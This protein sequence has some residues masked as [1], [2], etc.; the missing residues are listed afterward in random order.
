MQRWKA[1]ILLASIL[2]FIGI[3]MYLLLHEDNEIARLQIVDELQSPRQTDIVEAMQKRGVITAS[4]EEFVY[5]DD[6]FGSVGSIYVEEGQE[7]QIGEALFHYENVDMLAAAAEL[8]AK[9]EQLEL[10]S[11]QLA[12][13]INGLSGL[14]QPLYQTEDEEESQ[15]H[16]ALIEQQNALYDI[17][18]TEKQHQIEQIELEKT[19][20]EQSLTSLQE[21]HDQLE[22]IS[23]VTGIVKE[24][25]TNRNEPFLTIV[26]S[27]FIVGSEVTEEES[28]E[29]SEGLD[30]RVFVHDKE[31]I[32]G[33]LSEIAQF[34]TKEPSID[35]ETMYPFYVELDAE[36]PELKI[37][38]H[39]DLDIIQTEIE[40]AIIIPQNTLLHTGDETFVVTAKDGLLVPKS[41]TLGLS[42]GKSYEVVEGLNTNDFIVSSPRSYDLGEPFVTRL[43]LSEIERSSLA[44]FRKKELLL[45]AAEGFLK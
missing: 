36:S 24:I 16:Q 9:I 10:R 13:E 23:P 14:K 28:L 8:E 34:P 19:T 39:V 38:Y 35:T 15:Q 2:L 31:P 32:D 3:N 22:V 12:T 7:V 37:G 41:I 30:V 5:V 29:I 21:Q 42:T 43:R 40:D 18:I 1:Y 11:S 17:Q 26:S 20:Y 25:N 45:L 44:A 33:I 4:K 6:R 27:P